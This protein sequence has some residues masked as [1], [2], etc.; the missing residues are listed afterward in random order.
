MY[1][2]IVKSGDI[3]WKIEVKLDLIIINLITKVLN[4]IQDIKPKK[5]IKIDRTK[6]LSFLLST[7]FLP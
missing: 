3:N 7:L 2:I 5:K 1:T 6:V 4:H